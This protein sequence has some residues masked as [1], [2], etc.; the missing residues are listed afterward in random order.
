MSVVYMICAVC[1][2][3]DA[4]MMMRFCW[5]KILPPGARRRVL[6]PIFTYGKLCD[7]ISPRTAFSGKLRAENAGDIEAAAIIASRNRRAILR[8]FVDD[9]TTAMLK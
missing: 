9:G 2:C 7:L 4:G 8:T 5:L 3:S 1:D 6:A